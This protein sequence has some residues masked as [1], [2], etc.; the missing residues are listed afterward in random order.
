M[1]AVQ[2]I[3]A[4]GPE[5][6]KTFAMRNP[7]IS[8]DIDAKIRARGSFYDQALPAILGC[9]GA[10]EVAAIGD[11]V[12]D[13]KLGD[14]V[15]YCHGGLGR[16]PGSYAEYAVID[17]SY[18]R[19]KPEKLS[20][21]EAAVCPLALITAWEA[22]MD[23]AQLQAGETVLIHAGAGGV[24]H[25]AIQL[26][27]WKGARVL[28]TVSGP[29]RAALVKE[30]GADEAIN[31][32][33]ISVD[34]AVRVH[35]E[36][37]GADVV[38]DTV[39]PTIFPDCLKQAAVKGRVVTLLDPGPDVHFK[40]A[41]NKNLCISFE[42]MLTPMLRDDLPEWRQQQGDILDKCAELIDT[43]HLKPHIH[44]EYSLDQVAEA[45]TALEQSGGIGKRVIRIV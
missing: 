12:L 28:T 6:L 5:T 4:G 36:G 34:K 27:K 17:A 3:A 43:G 41:R 22:L 42:L 44:A 20:Y 39:G 15:W 24:G 18:L 33:D 32:Q 31:Y 14:P 30:W 38:F 16:E 40:D 26:A 45:H 2:M 10:G 37:R 25:L 1:K 35:T 21:A 9:D 7:D 8:G 23:R 13:F 19:A 29:S 11:A